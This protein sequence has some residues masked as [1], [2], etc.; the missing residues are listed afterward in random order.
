MV[1]QELV[2]GKRDDFGLAVTKCGLVGIAPNGSHG[3]YGFQLAKDVGQADVA[4][5]KDVFNTVK[6]PGN[7]RIK[8]VV[9]V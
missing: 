7:P 9:G 3:G 6:E 5:M 2:A 4:G 1:N 8:N